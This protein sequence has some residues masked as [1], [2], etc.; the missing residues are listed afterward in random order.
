M[1][2]KVVTGSLYLRSFISYQGAETTCLE[3]KLGMWLASVQ[4][5]LGVDFLH[6]QTAYAELQKS[7][8]QE[9]SFVHRFTPDIGSAFGKV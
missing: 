3:Q 9:S 7:L 8:H 6:L 4:N 5:L 2:L 1:G